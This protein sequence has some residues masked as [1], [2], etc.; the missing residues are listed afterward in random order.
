M[1][2]YLVFILILICSIVNCQ[3]W[4]YSSGEN[5]FD[6]VYRTSS[7]KGTGGSFPYNSPTLVVNFFEKTEKP[8]IYFANAGYAGCDYKRLYFKFDNDDKI[9]EYRGTSNSDND[10]WFIYD[11]FDNDI[12]TFELLNKFMNH[13]YFNVRLSSDCG[14]ADYKFTLFGSTAAINFVAKNWIDETRVEFIKQQTIIQEEERKAEREKF[15][16]DS[17][18][19]D[20]EQRQSLNALLVREKKDSIIT[21]L[22]KLYPADNHNVM[23]SKGWI[24]LYSKRSDVKAVMEVPAN[25][26]MVVDSLAS[27]M[28]SYCKIIFIDTIEVNLFAPGQLVIK[29]KDLE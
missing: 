15:I 26:L 25:T 8:N 9:Y 16:Y 10:S 27:N 11:D 18:W 19:K 7:V 4:T 29:L 2:K 3:K 23:V 13:S 12:T 20:K 28:P 6:G 5:A 24:F 22:K 17:I 14:K 21:S 1:K